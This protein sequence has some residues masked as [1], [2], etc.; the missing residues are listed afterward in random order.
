MRFDVEFPLR[1][2]VPKS[3]STRSV[4]ESARETPVLTECDVAVFGGGPAGICAAAAAAR[5]GKYVVLVERYGF[6]GGVAT[7]ANVTILHSLYG[8]DKKTKIIGGLPEE[9]IRRLQ[10]A[11]AAYNRA[12]DGETAHWVICTETAKLVFD[13]VVIGS[14]AKPFFHAYLAGALRKGKRIAAAFIEGKSGRQAILANVYIDCTGDADLIRRG[15]V[16]TQL[17]NAAGACQAPSLCF[18]VRGRKPGAIPLSQIQAELFKTPMDYNGER[19][20]CLLWGTDGVRDKDEVMMAGVRVPNV[21]AADSNDF[22]RAEVEGRYQLRWILKRL[23]TLRGWEEAYLTDIATQ[24]GIRESHRI[25]ADHRLSRE[26]VLYGKD[27]EDAIAQGTYPIDIHK[28]DGPGITFEY[29]DGTTQRVAG[30]RSTEKGRWDGQPLDSAPRTTLCY[31]VPYRCLIPRD[32]DNVLVAGRC[33]GASHESAG[34]IRVMINCMQFGQAAG[35]AAAMV[36]T[37]G[38]VRQVSTKLLQE[39]LIEAGVPLRIS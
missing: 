23:K 16:E 38:N 29:L 39:K 7:A 5:A 2:I 26:E 13:D 4:T 19:Y 35:A 3:N 10:A 28:P 12:K 32:L 31:Q 21:N 24:I 37:G 18:R 11:G 22:S 17:G 14:G 34:A 8:T 20:P 6:L 27:F 1:D 30:D 36:P 25:I 9:V 15:G 33:I